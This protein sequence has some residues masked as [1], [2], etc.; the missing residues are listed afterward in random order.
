LMTFVCVIMLA[1]TTARP[2]ATWV[3]SLI[4]GRQKIKEGER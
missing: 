2:A 1:R 4:K 3:V